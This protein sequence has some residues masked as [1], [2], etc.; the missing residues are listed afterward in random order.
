MAT[1]RSVIGAAVVVASLLALA[2][3]ESAAVP[4]VAWSSQPGAVVQ[5]GL[6][7]GKSLPGDALVQN[8]L[9]ALSQAKDLI[10]LLFLTPKLST[11][12]FAR[13]DASKSSCFS[14]LQGILAESG[15][16][17]FAPRVLASSSGIPDAL[18]SLTW[19]NVSRVSPAEALSL[20]LISTGRHLVVVE[21]QQDG[22]D[23]DVTTQLVALDR[24]VAN[25]YGQ[26][27]QQDGLNVVALLS[28]EQPAQPTQIAQ[29]AAEHQARVRRNIDRLSKDATVR[30]Q[31][32]HAFFTFPIFMGIIV[33]LLV[34][35]IA[36]MGIYVIMQTQNPDRFAS[37]S[38]KPL[39]VPAN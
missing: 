20:R 19:D 8:H 5:D 28:A 31:E 27:S 21:L 26:L 16:Q 4:V 18:A 32:K 17:L 25:V 3:A 15:S 24:V 23:D 9:P 34:L 35:F 30:L 39:I 1:V 29:A 38:D 36:L 33:T 12:D 14:G 6:K 10:A 37:S 2:H 7:A 13:Q 11:V 22:D